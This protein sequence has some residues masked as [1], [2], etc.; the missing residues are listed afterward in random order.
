MLLDPK[1]YRFYAKISGAVFLKVFLV[2]AG[3]IG[4][5]WLDKK[6]DTYPLFL[7]SLI[8]VGLG[9]GFWYILHVANRHK[10]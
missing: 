2:F 8:C 4:G 6:F 10:L 7:F 9:I 3:F 1:M 5:S